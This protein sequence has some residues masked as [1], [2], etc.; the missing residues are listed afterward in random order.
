MIDQVVREVGL[1]R[2]QRR[3]LHDEIHGRRLTYREIKT[4]AKDILRE[5]PGRK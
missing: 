3:L 1:S 5:Y 4:L 2:G